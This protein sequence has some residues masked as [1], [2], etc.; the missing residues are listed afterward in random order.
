MSATAAAAQPYRAETILA[1]DFGAANTRALLLDVVEGEFRLV[2]VGEAPSTCAA[3]FHDASEGLRHALGRLQAITGRVM[4]DSTA[5]LIM[6]VNSEGQ[7]CDTFVA[8]FS[9]GAPLR[10]VLV[11]LLPEA[12]LRN[13]RRLAE[14]SYLNVVDTL[15]LIDRRKQDQQIEAI[16]KAQPDVVILTGG[17]DGGAQSALL[18]LVETVGVA[19][20]LLPDDRRPAVFYAGNQALQGR[21]GE[22]LS[23]LANFHLGP[24][25]LPE[26]NHSNLESG[27]SALGELV[28]TLRARRIGG[29]ADFDHYAAGRMYPTALAEGRMIHFLSRMLNTPRGILSVNVGSASTTV[30]AAFGGELYL[31]V[32]SDLGVGL[33]AW[34]TIAS[35]PWTEFARWVPHTLTEAEVREFGLWRAV[36]PFTIPVEVEDLQRELA[37]A[38]LALA[39][40]L[41]RARTQWPTNVPGLHH[42]LMPYCDVLIGGG[43]VLGCAPGPGAAALVLLD[44]VQPIGVTDLMLDRHHALAAL[45]ALASA[46]ALASVQV[47]E[48]D[49]L[50][51]LG[52]AV[53]WVSQTPLPA[54]TP[55]GTATLVD[56]NQK[57]STVEVR[58]GELEVLPLPLGQTGKL[59]LKPRPGVDVGAGP[60]RARARPIEV[61][62]SMVGVILDGRGR[63]LSLPATEAQRLE[64]TQRWWWKLAGL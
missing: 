63:P 57:S 40:A 48:S 54:G 13:A 2:A 1:A 11:G 33:S 51:R 17:T 23:G 59:T 31:T 4:L 38:R 30:A 50:L 35:Q 14:S 52:V 46:N 62:G 56:A 53:S 25:V 7:G 15:S 8:T 34:T 22:M 41:R 39:G 16:V 55:L 36:H 26:L 9:A 19:S 12:S 27:R 28:K 24:N 3:P 61:D 32:A 47:L 42:S 5:Q 64:A 21:I 45:G 10:A 37:L 20:F 60:G 18:K 6:P 49:A 58:V 43:A 29:L 44:A